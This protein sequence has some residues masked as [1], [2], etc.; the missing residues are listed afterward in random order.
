MHSYVAR[1]L[2]DVR[3]TI[4]GWKDEFDLGGIVDEIR[5]RFGNTVDINE[6][7]GVNA[8][9]NANPCQAKRGRPRWKT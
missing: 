4:A 2:L 3:S 6:L 8:G 9:E 1:I 5:R 7:P